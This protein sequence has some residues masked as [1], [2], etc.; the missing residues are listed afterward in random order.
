MNPLLAMKGLAD[1]FPCGTD[2]EGNQGSDEALDGQIREVA[3]TTALTVG[4][5]PREAD[6]E[7]RSEVTAEPSFSE[8]LD[9]QEI[10]A[11]ALLILAC[12]AGRSFARMWKPGMND[13]PHSGSL[14]REEVLFERKRPLE[15]DATFSVNGR[16]WLMLK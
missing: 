11:G 6:D 3:T 13:I 4:G 7:R 8:M 15:V 10:E 1:L 14:P 5:P 16:P 2:V 9:E 12:M